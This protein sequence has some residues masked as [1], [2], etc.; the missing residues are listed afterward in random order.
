VLLVGLTLSHAPPLVVVG[1]AVKLTAVVLLTER[2]CDAG[3]VPPCWKPK[4][5]ALGVTVILA[6]VVTVNVTGTVREPAEDET[7]IEPEYVPAANVPG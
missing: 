1:V 5:R 2:L 7:A 3:D 4:A 6:A